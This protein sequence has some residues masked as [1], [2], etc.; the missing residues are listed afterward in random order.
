VR[1]LVRGIVFAW[2]NVWVTERFGER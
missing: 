2:V 1:D